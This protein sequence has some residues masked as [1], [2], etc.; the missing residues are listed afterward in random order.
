MHDL[1]RILRR[2]LEGDERVFIDN[3]DDRVAND[4]EAFKSF[5][6]KCREYE[7]EID[8]KCETKSSLGLNFW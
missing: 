4:D 2:V 3:K 5:R 8:C 7:R 1:C 6:F